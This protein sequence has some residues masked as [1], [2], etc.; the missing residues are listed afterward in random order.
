VSAK[1]E[2]GAF[3]S[4]HPGHMIPRIEGLMSRQ[5]GLITRRQ[6]L[7]AGLPAEAIDRLTRRGDWVIVR[8]G[9]YTDRDRWERLTRVE[10]QQRTR[11]RAASMRIGAPH[12]MSHDSAALELDLPILRARQPM[13]HVTRPGVVG[14]HLRHGVKH[15]LAPY[16]LSQ[17]VVVHGR[18]VL[19]AARTAADIARE[20]G[21]VPGVVACDSALRAGASPRDFEEAIAAM[22]YWPG[23]TVSRA[24]W[25][26]A[27]P[28][29]DSLGETLSRLVVEALG[30]GR[31]ETQFGLTDGSRT[32]FCDLR[33]GRH[34]FEFDGLLKYL[35][36]EDGGL[37][38]IDPADVVW[39][40]KQRQD[41]L[42]GFKLG[43]S[44][45][46][47]DDV[48]G[49]RREVTMRRLEREYLDTC[50][51]FGTN[52]DDLTPY[53]VRRPPRRRAA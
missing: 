42:C 13:T 33:L 29:A 28:G 30:H 45:L 39:Y 3:A 18:P 23:V 49:S 14:S 5:L 51:R 31:P 43:M 44:R 4:I 16:L 38:T 53:I 21:F 50:A 35:R 32:A 24:S 41:W 7:E 20:H 25:D 9:V 12:V 36:V 6:A 8:R 15:H 1:R 40:E 47:W 17:V 46:V 27:D 19:G 52:V 34:L 48:Y 26:A 11:D 10:D 22:A 2:Q 37:A